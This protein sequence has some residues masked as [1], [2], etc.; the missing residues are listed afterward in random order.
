MMWAGGPE[1]D[2]AR[3]ALLWCMSRYGGCTRSQCTE[4]VCGRCGLGGIQS[5]HRTA[6]LWDLGC[7]DVMGRYR[8]VGMVAVAP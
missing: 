4:P 7:G 1:R 2:R 8:K 3:I 5:T 6:L